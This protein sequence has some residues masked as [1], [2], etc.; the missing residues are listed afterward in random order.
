MPTVSNRA[1]AVRGAATERAA[2]AAP[3]DSCTSADANSAAVPKRSAGNFSSP[4]STAVSSDGVTAFRVS[5]GRSTLALITLATTACTLEPV[6]GGSPVSI[7]YV[8]A[9]SE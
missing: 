7:S 2:A 3:V 1:R 8:T 6:N 4:R 5:D 9:A